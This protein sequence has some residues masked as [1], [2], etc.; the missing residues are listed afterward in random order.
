MQE[1]TTTLAK[2]SFFIGRKDDQKSQD[3]AP[4]GDSDQQERP[5]Y[6]HTVK[7][8]REKET[9]DARQ[10]SECSSAL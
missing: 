3:L 5:T 1:N 10:S 2:L 4:G 7:R 8:E 9:S 6:E